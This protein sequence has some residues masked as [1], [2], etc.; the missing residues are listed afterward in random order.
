MLIIWKFWKSIAGCTKCPRGPNAT[1]GPRVWDICHRYC[2]A[3]M[4]F[5]LYIYLLRWN[6]HCDD[7]ITAMWSV[8]VFINDFTLICRREIQ[9]VWV[10]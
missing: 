2:L 7:W 3:T 5:F 9:T 1:H 6:L 4:A 8:K 10:K